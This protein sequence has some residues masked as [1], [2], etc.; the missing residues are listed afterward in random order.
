[1]TEQIFVTIPS[2]VS[3]EGNGYNQLYVGGEFYEF[4]SWP[5]SELP[6]IVTEV[7]VAEYEFAAEVTA[8]NGD[9]Q[10]FF[11]KREVKHVDTGTDTEQRND[12]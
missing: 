5:Y 11:R 7:R 10:T 2:V 8:M 1:M 4:H 12:S 3:T 6:P 9:K